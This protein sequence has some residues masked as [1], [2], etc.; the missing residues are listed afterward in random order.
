MDAFTVSNLL[1]S[2]CDIKGLCEQSS[3]AQN[4]DD[5]DFP[6]FEVQGPAQNIG[7]IAKRNGEFY[8]PGFEVHGPA[9][10]IGAQGRSVKT[11]GASSG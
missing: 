11:D 5:F 2:A 4:L 9:Q 1:S 3:G 8:F 10:N 6:G 7:G